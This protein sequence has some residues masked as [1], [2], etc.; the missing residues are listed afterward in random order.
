M[1]GMF[2]T[3]NFNGDVSKWD[4]SRVA[5]ISNMFGDATSFNGDISK[6]VVSSVTDMRQ[7]F[8]SSNFSGDISKWNVSIVADM[9]S[10]FAITKFNGDISK[11]DVS[12]V[13][14][15]NNMFGD[16]TSFNCDILEVGC[17]KGDRYER[18]VLGC[19]IFQQWHLKV[20]HVA[21]YKRV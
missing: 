18:H 6:W 16:A 14:D 15:M 7:T 20:G 12:R 9:S 5:D 10:M 19:R 4:M 13:T 11:W 8:T 2:A 3:T 1:S 21:E 17:V